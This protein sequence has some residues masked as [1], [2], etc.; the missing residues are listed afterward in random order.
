MTGFLTIVRGSSLRHASTTATRKIAVSIK[1]L[2]RG[3]VVSVISG[4]EHLSGGHEQVL[5]NRPQTE[6]WEK[7]ERANHHNRR[8][9]Q[10]GEQSTGHRESPQRRGGN[11]L[12]G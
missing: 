3:D 1:D 9:Q 11:F 6:S 8:Y 12:F 4:L 2:A 10:A 5:E 7:S